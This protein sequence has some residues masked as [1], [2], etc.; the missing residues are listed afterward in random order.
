MKFYNQNDLINYWEGGKSYKQD[1]EGGAV[2]VV[3]DASRN[4]TYVTKKYFE[5][6]SLY[7]SGMKQSQKLRVKLGA[8][9]NGDV[10]QDARYKIVYQGGRTE[11]HTGV[12]LHTFIDDCLSLW[13]QPIK[14]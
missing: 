2:T 3:S 10:V 7:D 9:K 8:E 14:T 6:K 13:E 11:D 5:I 12:F 1:A 4:L